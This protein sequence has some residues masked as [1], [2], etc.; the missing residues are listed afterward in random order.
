MTG[1]DR[2]WQAAT[3]HQRKDSLDQAGCVEEMDR[4]DWATK[5]LLLIYYLTSKVEYLTSPDLKY[6]E[7]LGTWGLIGQ[8]VSII[9]I[10][11]LTWKYIQW[12]AD[13]F[14]KKNRC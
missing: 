12:L 6:Q 1:N 8:A 9:A 13:A 14:K 7:D 2:Q 4:L 10:N 11:F 5:S 3:T